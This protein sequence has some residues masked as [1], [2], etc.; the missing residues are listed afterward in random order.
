MRDLTIVTVIRAYG[1]VCIVTFLLGMSGA[2]RV[3]CTEPKYNRAVTYSGLMHVH[4][5][6]CYMGEEA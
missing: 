4:K 5:A 1:I 2:N 3:M 6:G